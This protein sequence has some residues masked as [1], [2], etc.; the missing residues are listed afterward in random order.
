[1]D[2]NIV[3]PSNL[4]KVAV[5]FSR[6]IEPDD[7]LFL[8]R[9]LRQAGRVDMEN[10]FLHRIVVVLGV[11]KRVKLVCNFDRNFL[12]NLLHRFVEAFLKKWAWIQPVE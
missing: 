3:E 6:L 11:M 7:G 1:L 12:L 4:F 10:I 2:W 8:G 9:K 5:H